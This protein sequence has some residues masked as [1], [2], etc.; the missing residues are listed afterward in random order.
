MKHILKS[1]TYLTLSILVIIS[2]IWI[3]GCGSDGTSSIVNV[4]TTTPTSNTG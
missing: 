3:A 1:K 4:P 2:I